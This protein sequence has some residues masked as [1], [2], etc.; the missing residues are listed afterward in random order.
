MILF[1]EDWDRYPDATWDLNTR[2]K[3]FLD[4]AILLRDM[5]V[6]NHLWP[7]QI[8]DAGLIGVDPHDPNISPEMAA[9]VA[10][11]CKRN[12]FYFIREVARDP[13]GS[14]EDPIFFK[15]NRGVMA[16]YWMF[17]NNILTIL[18]MIRQ[19]GKSF[20]IDWLHI[21]LS[22]I[23][24]TKTEISHITKDEKLRGRELDR[25]K[26]ME[27]ALPPYMKQRSTRDPGNTEVMRISSLGNYIKFYLPNKSPKI[28]D[29]IGRGMTTPVVVADEWAYLF[30]NFITIPVMLSASLAARDISRRKN[31]PYGTVFATTSGKRD[32]PEGRYA[33]KV[34]SDAAVMTEKFFDS[35]N[36]EFLKKAIISASPGKKLHVNCTYNHRQLGYTD[37]WL[38]ERLTESMNEDP[39]QIRADFLNEWPSGSAS[40]PFDQDTA[41]DIRN[42]EVVDYYTAIV[43][44]DAYTVRWYYD[45]KEIPYKLQ[46]AHVLAVDPSQAVGRDSIGIVLR[47][48]ETGEVAMACDINEGNLM[49]VA[50]WLCSFL[51]QWSSVTAVIERKDQGPM[52][53]D[54][55]ILYLMAAGIN[56]FR[57]LYNQVVQFADEFPDRF[58]EINSTMLPSD[59]VINKYKKLFGWNTSGGSGITSRRELYG[60]TLRSAARYTRHSVR[61]RK[62]ILQILGL[63][64]RGGRVDHGEGEH[65]DLVIGWMLS[66]WLLTVG[67]NLD[68]YGINPSKVLS[69][70]KVYQ[71]ASSETSYYEQKRSSEARAMVEQISREIEKEPD[72]YVVKFLEFQLEKSI[73]DLSEQD[74]KHISADD[75]IRNLRE[76][77]SRRFSDRRAYQDTVLPQNGYIDNGP[78]YMF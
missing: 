34:M 55:L 50:E 23:R 12:F 4:Y 20:G 78:M 27:L 40:S 49:Y 52:I 13:A 59:E 63:E 43:G 72:D 19:T 10:V 9:R 39:V 69:T 64:I 33:Y 61:D 66:Y 3:S 30:N 76:S 15:A 26:G 38:Q 25:L 75:L 41:E 47:N 70:N 44:K 48:A 51:V 5:G 32:T 14:P 21:Y 22:N 8:H 65:D 58:A 60:T 71:Q 6:E 54:Y 7:L 29:I 46:S 68:Y 53:I 1:K 73:R 36:Y 18:I 11:E 57:R 31:E 62:L 28:A 35:Q 74:R 56:P 17:F 67:R 77:R 45:E 37:E 2:N 42:S 24:L 16:L